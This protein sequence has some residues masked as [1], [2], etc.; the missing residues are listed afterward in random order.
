MRQLNIGMIGAVIAA[1]LAGGCAADGSPLIGSPLTTA[2]IDGSAG[3]KAQP[4]VD[5]ACVALT[6]KIDALRKE[7][8]AERIEKASTGKSATVSVKRDSLAKI[9]ELDK[10]NAEFQAKCATITPGAKTA[11]ATSAS[12]TGAAPAAQ[13]PSATPAATVAPVT[14]TAAK[15]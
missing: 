11:A 5:P 4:K 12:G 13:K 14:P 1:A 7:G 2:S 10:A 9:T 3:D 15:N 8:V 6:A